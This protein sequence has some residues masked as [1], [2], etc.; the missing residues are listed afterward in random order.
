MPAKPLSM[1]VSARG[2]RRYI[3]EAR[4]YIEEA[5]RY[6]GRGATLHRTK[7]PPERASVDKVERYIERLGRYREP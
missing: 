2:G 4:R 1:R 5:R 6:I 3:E 7:S